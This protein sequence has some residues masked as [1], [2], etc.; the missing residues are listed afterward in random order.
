VGPLLPLHGASS[1]CRWRRRPPDMEGICKYIEE[2]VVESLQGV[3]L[4]LGGWAKG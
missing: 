3:V 1:G 2:A 4:Q